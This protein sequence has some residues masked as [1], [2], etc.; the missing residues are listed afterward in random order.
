MIAAAQ[1]AEAIAAATGD[2]WL[3]IFAAYLRSSA[4]DHHGAAQLL[5]QALTPNSPTLP[6]MAAG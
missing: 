5:E 2:S 1:Q 6:A 3:L 4:N